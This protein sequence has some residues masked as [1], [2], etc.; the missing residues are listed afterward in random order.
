MIVQL[1]D[2]EITLTPSG[3]NTINNR[4]LFTK[5]AE[6]NAIVT[7]VQLKTNYFVSAGDMQ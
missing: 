2:G 6:K 1:G 5:T 4:S 3:S 7:L